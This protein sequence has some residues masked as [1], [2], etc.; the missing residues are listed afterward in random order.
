MAG[1]AALVGLFPI[2]HLVIGVLILAGALPE[3]QGEP[4]PRVIGL[5][6]V[7][8]AGLF[9]AGAWA[10]A[11]AV[12]LAGRRLSQRRSYTYCLVVACIECLFMPFGTVLGIFTIIVLTRPSVKG[13]FGVEGDG[14]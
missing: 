8:F 13:R 11:V 9:I 1:I 12:L 3:G 4:P 7:M 2:I 14:G 6:F 10:L 5:V